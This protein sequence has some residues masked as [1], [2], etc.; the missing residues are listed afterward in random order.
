MKSRALAPLLAAALCI[1]LYAT[2]AL[3]Q[4]SV[5][6]TISDAPPP[7]RVERVHQHRPGWVWVPG[8][9]YWEGGRHHWDDGRWIKARPGQR[10]EPARWERRGPYYRYVAG[11]WAPDREYHDRGRRDHDG[12]RER[13]RHDN[14]HGNGHKKHHRD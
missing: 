11:G 8:T 1:G 14:G 13:D 10:W 9:W 3:A 12:H 6:V 2:P 5:S 7:P 4:L